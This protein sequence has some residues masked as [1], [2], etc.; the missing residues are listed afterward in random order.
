MQE[1]AMTIRNCLKDQWSLTEDLHKDKIKFSTGW[2]D[3]NADKELNIIISEDSSIDDTWEIGYG[4]I[5]VTAIHKIEVR[6]NVVDDT[7]KGPGVAKDTRW[8][9]VEEIRRIIKANEAGLTDLWRVKLWGA[10]R[11]LDLLRNKPPILTYSK[12]ITVEYAV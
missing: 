11:P 10:G 12:R 8:K 6:V 4:T 2:F 5:K 9:M 7:N 1:P 3:V